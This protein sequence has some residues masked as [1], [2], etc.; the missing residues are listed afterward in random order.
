MTKKIL[1]L[2][3][4]KSK[5]DIA[6]NNYEQDLRKLEDELNYN[7]DDRKLLLEK[8]VIL[9]RLKRYEEIVILADAVLSRQEDEEFLYRKAAALFYGQRYSEALLLFDELLTRKPAHTLILGKKISSLIFLGRYSEAIDLFFRSDLTEIDN[10]RLFNNIGVALMESKRYEDAEKQ[11]KRALHIRYYKVTSYYNLCRVY[12]RSGKYIKLFYCLALYL[13]CVLVSLFKGNR[14]DDIPGEESF[15][16]PGLLFSGDSQH[17]EVSA[18]WKLL[19]TPNFWALCND[20]FRWIALNIPMDLL[21]DSNFKGDIDIIVSMPAEFPPSEDGKV[22]FRSFEVKTISINKIGE[23]KSLKRGKRQKIVKQLNKMA[24]FGCEQIFLLQM[25]VI[26][27][28]YSL[29]NSFP[30]PQLEVAVNSLAPE[31]KDKFGYVVTA[32]EP[33]RTHSEQMGGILYPFFNVL[34]TKPRKPGGLF[35]DLM[36]HLDAFYKKEIQNNENISGIAVITYCK[37]CKVLV[38]LSVGPDENRECPH[39]LSVLN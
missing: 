26:E 33:S 1:K 14:S 8:V 27:R 4:W 28:G 23:V 10:N 32:H 21:Q 31:L 3:H 39:C 13:T 19:H 30:P 5:T 36:Q 16:G 20:T 37:L 35:L 25:C 17:R 11:L 29:Q 2:F 38:V 18:I 24:S 6:T 12:Y 34:R 22:I 9:M 7:P 15:V